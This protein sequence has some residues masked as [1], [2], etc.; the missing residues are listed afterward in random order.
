MSVFVLGIDPGKTTGLGLI[1]VDG[2]KI[3]LQAI[4]ES[5][6]VSCLDYLDLL[7]KADRIIIENFRVRPMKA[8][9][10]AF[11][12]DAM[13]APQVIGAINA[14]LANLGKFSVL[15]DASVKPVG[16]GWSNQRYVKG[17]KGTHCQ[18]AVAHAVFYAVKILKANP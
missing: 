14:Q 3:S 9:S 1:E 6:D 12:W 7:Q 4:R 17:K 10:G 18:D 11:D 16:Y 8:R 2:V 15:Q 5:R 13:I